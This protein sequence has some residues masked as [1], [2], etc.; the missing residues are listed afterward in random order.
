M[1]QV[2]TTIDYNLLTLILC[3][4]NG[5]NYEEIISFSNSLNIYR[6]LY[7]MF[8]IKLFLNSIVFF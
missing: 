4:I 1:K 2:T 8:I 5:N 7:S 3:Q 6:N